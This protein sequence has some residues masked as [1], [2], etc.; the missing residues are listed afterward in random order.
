MLLLGAGYRDTSFA[1]YST[2]ATFR[3]EVSGRARQ[4][5]VDT[6]T[7][8]SAGVAHLSTAA[9]TPELWMRLLP[10]HTGDGLGWPG[11]LIVASVASALLFL[12][13]SGLMVWYR[14][15]KGKKT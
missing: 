9:D 12:T 4:S 7:F 1:G 6:V 15:R 8:D 14:G 10:W 3:A 2:D 13:G 11:K 5:L